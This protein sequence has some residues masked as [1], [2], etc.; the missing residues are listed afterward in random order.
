M[1]I[2]GWSGR[3]QW[4]G[5]PQPVSRAAHRQAALR[6]GRGRAGRTGTGDSPRGSV[7]PQAAGEM[8]TGAGAD[9]AA[10]RVELPSRTMI[11][12]AAVCCAASPE[13]RQS[14]RLGQANSLT[15]FSL[16]DPAVAAAATVGAVL[17]RLRPLHADQPALGGAAAQDRVPSERPDRRFLVRGRAVQ[18]R[19]IAQVPNEPSCSPVA[20]F[21]GYR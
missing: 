6:A 4:L 18:G 20:V 3:R 11:V 12:C 21:R 16:P 7:A 17:A 10:V 13:K 8:G 19:R 2:V 5:R 14:C 1:R 15:L 9:D